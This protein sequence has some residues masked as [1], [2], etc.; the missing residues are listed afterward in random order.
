M[1]YALSNDG[2]RN[3]AKLLKEMSEKLDLAVEV[4]LAEPPDDDI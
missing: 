3:L 4:N 2:C 1:G